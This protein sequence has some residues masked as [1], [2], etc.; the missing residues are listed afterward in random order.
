MNQYLISPTLQIA[1]LQFLSHTHIFHNVAINACE[2]NGAGLV[3]ATPNLPSTM[4]TLLVNSNCRCPVTTSKS[5]INCNPNF[6]KGKL[7]KRAEYRCCYRSSIETY[8]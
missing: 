7:Q 8:T 6:L 5:P 2:V 3:P 4:R 1:Q